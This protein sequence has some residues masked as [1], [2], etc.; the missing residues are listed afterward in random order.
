M[1]LI[2]IS[3]MTNETEHPTICTIMPYVLGTGHNP[4]RE[5]TAGISMSY[6]AGSPSLPCSQGS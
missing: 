2:C 1:A 3:L 5:D 4:Q 6:M